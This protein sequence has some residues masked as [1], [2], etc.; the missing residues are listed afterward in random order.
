[1]R[2][3][4]TSRFAGQ[5]NGTL[6]LTVDLIPGSDQLWNKSEGKRV[7]EGV[8]HGSLNTLLSEL[9]EAGIETETPIVERQIPGALID[10]ALIRGKKLR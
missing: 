10:I 7:D 2:R 6:L 1:M 9:R 5:L 8:E 3:R 4:W